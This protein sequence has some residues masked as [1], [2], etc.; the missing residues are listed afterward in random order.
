MSGEISDH[1]PPSFR[2]R[3]VAASRTGDINA[4]DRAIDWG[5]RNYPHLVRPRFETLE[6][7]TARILKEIAR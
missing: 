3:L 7:R 2:D 4:I 6:E 1:Y 5:V